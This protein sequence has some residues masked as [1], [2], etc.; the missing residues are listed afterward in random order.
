MRILIKFILVIAFLSVLTLGCRDSLTG[1]TDQLEY[2]ENEAFN[3]IVVESPLAAE[4]YQPG[5]TV[6][7]KWKSNAEIKNVKLTLLKKNYFELVLVEQMENTGHYSWI[8]PPSLTDSHHYKL[9]I[10][11]TIREGAVGYSREFFVLR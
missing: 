11:S 10:Q 6:D 3:W 8:I 5:D 4:I 1:E 9:R 7:I 2:S